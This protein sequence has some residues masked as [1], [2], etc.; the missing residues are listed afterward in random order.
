MKFKI[1]ILTGCIY[2]IAITANAQK[3]DWLKAP[4]NPIAFSYKLEHFNL[5]KGV[6]AFKEQTFNKDGSLNTTVHFD[7]GVKYFYENGFLKNSSRQEKFEFNTQ[8]YISKYSKLG[9]DIS[10]IWNYK[11]NNKGLMIE[12][13]NE[14]RITTY[15][16]D[17]DDRIIKESTKYGDGKESYSKDL[18]YKKEGDILEINIVENR[19]GNKTSRLEAYKNGFQIYRINENANRFDVN[20]RLASDYFTFSEIENKQI[21]IQIEN[22]QYVSPTMSM[23]LGRKDIKVYV[24][25]KLAPFIPVNIIDKKQVV[26]WDFSQNKYLTN[27]DVTVNK[28]QKLNLETYTIT[29]T[30]AYA[31]IEKNYFGL[32]HEGNT[33]TMS[34][35]GGVIKNTSIKE[36]FYFTYVESLNTS[37]KIKSN[38]PGYYKATPIKDNH[39]LFF[40]KNENGQDFSVVYKAEALKTEFKKIEQSTKN[41]TYVSLYYGLLTKKEIKVVLPSFSEAAPNEVYEA[42]ELENFESNLK[43]NKLPTKIEIVKNVSKPNIVVNNEETAPCIYGDCKDGY[44]AKKIENNVIKGLFLKGKFSLYGE[45]L[46]ANG[47][48]YKGEFLHGIRE[49]FGV[50]YWKELNQY[51]YG[52][53]RSGNVHGFG[54][55][56]KDGKLLQAGEYENGKQKYNYLIE[57]KQSNLAGCEGDCENGF[58]K[59]TY[60]N[61]DTYEGFWAGNKQEKVGHYYFKSVNFH[62]YG[63]YSSNVMQGPGLYTGPSLTY[64]GDFEDNQLTGKGIKFFSNQIIE[65]G[66]WDKGKLVIK[67]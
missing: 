14:D 50:Y 66:R 5:P 38:S 58:G 55:Y 30:A 40:V 28:G 10:G 64:I 60:N 35:Y 18:T 65:A 43:L 67:Y 27:L 42:Y 57:R 34:A 29:D 46:Y 31:Q 24:N 49:G 61:G 20:Q 22:A 9:A 32:L 53:W 52:Y 4:V 48:V 21:N 17:G 13:Q 45:R 11:Y 2:F 1:I 36:G 44:G 26:L 51:Y 3:I 8:G 15:Q 56:V 39:H 19:N 6:F 62:Y 16:Y 59:F 47:D 41:T 37:F 12:R 63:S 25:G 23:P 54:F 7:R 33:Y